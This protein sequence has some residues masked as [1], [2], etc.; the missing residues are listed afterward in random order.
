MKKP[1]AGPGRTPVDWDA[2]RHRLESLEAAV[3]RQWQPAAEERQRILEARARALARPPAAAP[4][5]EMLEVVEFG[6]AGERYG[7]D[8]SFVREVLHLVQLTRLPGTPA[9]LLGIINVRGEILSVIDL[10]RIF[11]LPEKTLTERDRVLVLHSDDMSF[12]I[13]ADRI[14]GVR[15]VPRAAIQPPP[16]GRPGGSQDYLLGMTEDC[17]A[18][19]D[20]GRLL[21]DSRL[22]V[23]ETVAA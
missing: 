16:P 20:G 2:V 23:N 19:L 12:G 3:A 17:L 8:S 6:L 9:F 18:I 4:A 10:K 1:A 7:L 14:I 15:T 13:L 11:Q 21:G 5:G 22:V